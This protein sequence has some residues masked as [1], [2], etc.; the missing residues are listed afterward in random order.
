MAAANRSMESRVGRTNQRYGTKGERLVAGIVPLSADKTK[1]LMIQ[2]A[3]PG[4]WVLPKGGW[5]LDEPTAQQAAQ[6]EAWEEAGVICT[7]QRDLGV[8]PDMRPATLLTTSAPKASYQFFEAIV[9]RE[10]AQWPEMHKRKRQWVTYAQAA[11]AL[12]NRPELL[13]A[14]NRSSLRR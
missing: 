9:S 8:I 12:V 10:E 7:V 5:E 3:G 14:L 4:G 11:S 6:R 13:E 1:V 2:S